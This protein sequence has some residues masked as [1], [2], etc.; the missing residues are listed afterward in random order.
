MHDA[1]STP[2]NPWQPETIAVSAGRPPH[3]PGA[4]VNY[5]IGLSTTFHA[6]V[7]GHGYIREGTV[8]T[9]AFEAIMGQ[10][11][12]GH[13][14]VFSSGMATLNA[15]VDLLPANAKVVAPNHAYPGTSGRLRE[16]HK[17]QR[18]NLVEVLANDTTSWI[19]NAADADLLWIESPTN[20]LME[21]SDIR[22]II[23]AKS[24]K[25]LVV[26]DNTFMSPVFQLPL[27]LGADFSMN[28]A[29]KSISG[30]SDSLLGVLTAKSLELADELKKRRLLQGTFPGSL[31]LY[32][33]TRGVR[34]LH[35]R[36]A[37]SVQNASE[38]A[39]RLEKHPKVASVLYPGLENSV[40]Y[41]IHMSQA[42]GG[43]T[44][45]SIVLTGNAE[46][47][48]RVCAS[49]FLW[50]HATS[51]GGVESTL[52]RRRRWPAEPAITPESLLRLSVGIENVEDL[53]Q[54][55]N[56]ALG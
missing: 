22:K 4:P 3:V 29:T 11:E 14:V 7:L 28:S 13:S 53:W 21:I 39:R 5:P 36:A 26:V 18:I 24:A 52:E 27:E 40:D 56:Q 54:D 47:A 25:T 20:P 23:S 48:E 42:S 6:G 35:L 49:T 55:L 2:E 37:K 16:L 12:H 50:T 10:L 19:Q 38:L 44:V 31:E 41:E 15:V 46:E 1:H 51:L 9:E 17:V 34:T 45:M 43:G 8:G 32:L 33:A 30:H